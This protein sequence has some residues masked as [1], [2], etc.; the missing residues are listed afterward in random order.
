[1]SSTGVATLNI[2]TLAAGT[3]K[4]T[5]TYANDL[6]YANASSTSVTVLVTAPAYMVT[7]NVAGIAIHTEHTGTVVLTASTVGGYTGTLTASCGSGLPAGIQCTFVP[8]TL[9]F[10]GTNSTQTM[11]VVIADVVNAPALSWTP[12]GNGNPRTP[13][14]TMM[15]MIL[16][17]PGSLVGLFALRRRGTLRH[18]QR[19]S[20]LALVLCGSLVAIGS[21]SGCATG[22]NIAAPYG[23]F[24]L[25]ITVTDGVTSTTLTVTVSILGN[26]SVN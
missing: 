19:I 25:P 10:T 21:L 24:N 6:V 18:W 16:W 5:A 7:D 3:H 1:V 4:L 23:T 14:M 13:V 12:N 20:L 17:L 2:S 8:S 22:L 26:S 15:A 9:V 11:N